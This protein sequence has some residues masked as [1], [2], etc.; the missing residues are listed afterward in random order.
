[1]SS[2]V[3]PTPVAVVTGAAGQIGA[4]VSERLSNAGVQLLLVDRYQDAL[5][6]VLASVAQRSHAVGLVADVTQESTATHVL[7]KAVETFG[8]VDVLVNN[9]GIEGVVAPLEQ[10]DHPE[11]I[12]VFEVNVFAL[13]RM[14]TVFASYFRGRSSGRIVNLASGAGLNGTGMMT[15]YSASKH[16]VMGITRSLAQE[17]APLEV[18]VN[19]VCPGCVDSVMM[20]RI[21]TRLGELA[22]SDGPASFLSSIPMGRYC[23]PEEV[24]ETV[25]WLALDAPTYLTGSAL[26]IDGGMRS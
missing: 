2:T 8:Q 16:A 22:G 21:E 20:R 26:V 13:A 23:Q 3:Q 15:P 1:M 17:L 10:I 19:A 18:T 9:A 11:I 25:R 5:D 6:P 14:S 12:R 4:A 24:A 7:E